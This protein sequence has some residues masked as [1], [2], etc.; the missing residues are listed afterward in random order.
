MGGGRGGGYHSKAD[1]QFLS[2]LQKLE[3]RFGT[4]SD[5]R[6][7]KNAPRGSVRRIAS[8]DP[9][10]TAREFFQIASKGAQSIERKGQGFFKAK[11]ADE[12]IVVL[13]ISSK[14]DGSP[15]INFRPS[16]GASRT[17]KSHKIHF[18]KE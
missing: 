12:S 1:E 16:S 10:G 11:F 15:A 9:E 3:R 4:K 13:R 5:G 8:P 14:S 18:I 2:N 7:G 6:F 17:L